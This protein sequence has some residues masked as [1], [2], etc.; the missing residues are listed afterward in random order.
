MGVIRRSPPPGRKSTLTFT[1]APT[2]ITFVAR[3][4]N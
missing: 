2:C 1:S 4:H 3:H